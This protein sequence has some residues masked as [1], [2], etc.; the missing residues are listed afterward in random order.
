MNQIDK[1]FMSLLED[2]KEISLEELEKK[3]KEKYFKVPEVTRKSIEDFF[4][5]FNYWGS[6]NGE[7]NDFKEIENVCKSLKIN[8]EKYKEFYNELKDYRSKIVLYA[9]I[10]NF[11][12]YDFNTLNNVIEHTYSHYFDLDIIP[13]LDNEVVVDL[14]A[15]T[16]DTIDE[17]NQNYSFEN[18]KK[19]YAYEMSEDSLDILNKKYQNMDK[20]IVRPC[21]VSDTSG[22]GCLI[23]NQESSSANVL[24]NGADFPIVTLDEDI[25]CPISILKMDI[26]GSETKAL[27]GARKHIEENKP[28]M[29]ISVYHGFD[30]LIGIWKLIKEMNPNY[31]FYLRYYGGP[32]FPTEIVLYAI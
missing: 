15:Y 27:L 6:L 24:T 20:I 9:I 4:A 13:K 19:I 12:C 30:D 31:Q 5:K 2:I 32:I 18:V 21:A 22:M 28:K 8:H 26:E 17:L 11:Y 16:G 3:V 29:M 14:G 1:K 7:K 25:K 23:K 10:N